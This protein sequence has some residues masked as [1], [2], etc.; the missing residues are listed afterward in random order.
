M[1]SFLIIIFLIASFSISANSNRWEGVPLPQ[2]QLSDQTGK[3][4]TND[5][6][7]GQ[8][9]IVYF[10]PKDKTSGCTLEAQKFTED[11]QQFKKLNTE[12]IGVSY[13]DVDSHK[14]FA[15]LHNMPFILLADTNAQLSKA[16]KVDRLL[17]WPHASR[18]TFIVNPQGKI[19]YHIKDVTPKVHSQELLKLLKK[20]QKP[21]IK[22]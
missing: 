15:E 12:I 10:Y 2:F 8:W 14:E 18:Q 3:V 20:L 6:F 4:R 22:S 16:L 19:A 9:L 17:P 7:I 5:D 11:Y 13:D 21:N 1:K